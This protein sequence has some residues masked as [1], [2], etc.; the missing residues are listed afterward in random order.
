MGLGSIVERIGGTRTAVLEDLET[1]VCDAHVANLDIGSKSHD[2]DDLEREFAWV[3]VGAM[4]VI[5]EEGNAERTQ[6]GY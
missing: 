4:D 3:N 1:F 2:V 5:R 6:M